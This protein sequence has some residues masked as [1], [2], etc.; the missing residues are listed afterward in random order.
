MNDNVYKIITAVSILVIAVV[1]VLGSID[2]AEAGPILL[3]GDTAGI[4]CGPNFDFS[5]AEDEMD[6]E[7][8]EETTVGCDVEVQV[9][10]AKIYG[11][12]NTMEKVSSFDKVSYNFGFLAPLGERTRLALEFHGN[13]EYE[14]DNAASSEMDGLTFP[15]DWGISTRIGIV[16]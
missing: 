2:E 6:L 3:P 15:K 1:M 16:F 8:N 12:V 10:F 4:A 13:T 9:S 7:Y 5:N 14:L 11:G